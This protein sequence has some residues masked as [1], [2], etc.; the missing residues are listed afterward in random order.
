MQPSVIGRVAIGLRCD[1]GKYSR[2]LSRR[3]L[4]R[5]RVKRGVIWMLVRYLIIREMRAMQQR[6]RKSGKSTVQV[7]YIR[8]N[9]ESGCS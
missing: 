8:R 6:H 2:R 1:W 7:S 4:P 3:L 5:G 9:M